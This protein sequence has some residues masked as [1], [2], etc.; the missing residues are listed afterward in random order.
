MTSPVRLA[1][2]LFVALVLHQSL[3]VTLRIGDAH[4]Q[5]MLLVA[6]AGGLLAGS[7]RGGLI[8]FAA[9]LLAD[10]FVETPLGL[11]ALTFALVGFVVGS[12]QT[13]IV[14]TAWWISPLTALVASFTGVV[15]YG[16]LGALIGQAHFVSLHLLVLAG[17]VGAMNAVLAAP[18][19]RVMGWAL[20]GS[21]EKAYAR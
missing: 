3:F 17:G 14:H 1:S 4:P 8:G 15:L 10:L 13:G 2:V 5:L 6:V 19:V 21:D 12:A 16:L 11:S 9:G 20:G 7:E 18:V